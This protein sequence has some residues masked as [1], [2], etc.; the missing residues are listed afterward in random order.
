MAKD[1]KARFLDRYIV[2]DPE[3]CHGEPT[4]RGTR[5][6]SSCVNILDEQIVE[7]QRQNMG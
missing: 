6:T 3:I 1:K 7:S 5:I 4:F 2:I